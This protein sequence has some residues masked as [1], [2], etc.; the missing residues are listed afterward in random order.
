MPTLLM[1][2]SGESKVIETT[3]S[4][5]VA[6]SRPL[7]AHLEDLPEDMPA[8]FCVRNTFIDTAAQ[9][10]PSLEGFYRQREVQTCP[11]SHAGR[12]LQV[13][14]F[15][16]VLLSPAPPQV[17]S[18]AP[19]AQ[20]QAQPLAPPPVPAPAQAPLVAAAVLPTAAPPAT[21]PRFAGSAAAQ[22]VS[23]PHPLAAERA[24]PSVG[25]A[26]HASRQ[27]KPCGFFYSKGCDNGAACTFCH[28]CPPG[29][30]RRR[31]K[32]KFASTSKS[33]A[34]AQKLQQPASRN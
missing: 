17:L 15:Q 33:S 7:L 13:G 25:S 14:L 1:A 9:L 29:E 20:A 26:L 32:E 16:D 5:P 8:E 31:Q 2:R 24:V 4:K 10:S 22:T 21:A 30:K 12:L 34:P 6:K 11:S 28:V 19:M 23:P 18:T 3:A 27:C